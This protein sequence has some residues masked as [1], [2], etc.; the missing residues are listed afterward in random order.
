MRARAANTALFRGALRRRSPGA[1]RSPRRGSLDLWIPGSPD[2]WIPGSPD[3]AEPTPP[4]PAHRGRGPAQPSRSVPRSC[5]G[6]QGTT[7]PFPPAPPARHVPDRGAG[8]AA[9]RGSFR[10]GGDA[11][12]VTGARREAKAA[13]PRGGGAAS[14][15]APSPGCSRPCPPRSRHLPAPARPRSRS[16]R[17]SGRQRSRGTR[18]FHPGTRAGRGG[19]GAERAGARGEPARGPRRLLG[20]HRA[21]P[22]PS[23]SP[24]CGIASRW[25]WNIPAER[26]SSPSPGVPERSSSPCSGGIS[27]AFLW[28]RVLLP[29]QKDGAPLL[30]GWDKGVVQPGKE[31]L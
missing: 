11:V 20:A 1:C 17:T 3:R 22:E 9:R 6:P 8:G 26:D 10:R 13:S 12:T 28:P 24:R 5:P 7:K 31:K 15:P 30:R 19:A 14:L 27:C 16:R 2:R 18:R 29:V 4:A 25:F 21:I 23:Q